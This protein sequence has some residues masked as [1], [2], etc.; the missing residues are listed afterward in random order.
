MSRRNPP[1]EFTVEL[2]KGLAQAAFWLVS[3]VL[4]LGMWAGTVRPP[5]IATAIPRYWQA[6]LDGLVSALAVSAGLG[7]AAA[8]AVFGFRHG[9]VWLAAQVAGWFRYRRIWRRVIAGEELTETDPKRGVLVPRLRS[10]RTSPAGDVLTVE[11]LSKQAPQDWHHRAESLAKAFGAVSATVRLTNEREVIKLAFT[12]PARTLGFAA[13]AERTGQPVRQTKKK[14]LVPQ[15]APG[16]AL[17]ARAG[18]NGLRT[19]VVVVCRNAFRGS[20]SSSQRGA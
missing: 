14:V 18:H 8:V 15:P 9:R 11:L 12:R 16:P 20:R 5:D 6:F 19:K 17:V 13:G 2:V 3:F 1:S 7:L 10:V 4:I